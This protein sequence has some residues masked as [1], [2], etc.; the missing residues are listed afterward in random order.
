MDMFMDKLAQKLTAQEIIKANTAADTE[1]L[2]VLKSRIAEYD[3]CLQKL[4]QLVAEGSAKLQEAQTDRAGFEETCRKLEEQLK[5]IRAALPESIQAVEGSLKKECE[6]IWE[7]EQ[8]VNG[9]LGLISEQLSRIPEGE[10]EAKFASLEE[11][12]HKECVK[13]YRNVQAVVVDEC[14]K[15]AAS[16]K[17]AVSG[18]GSLKGRLNAVFGISV[19][20]MIAAI[21][22]IVLQML[23]MLGIRFF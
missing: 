18:I 11:S 4:Q 17:E 22:S 10:D 8:S 6:K 14:G 3:E 7:I 12:V 19:V 15:Q 21:G 20:A 5:D 23:S 9:N 2:N 1:E 16:V 13:V